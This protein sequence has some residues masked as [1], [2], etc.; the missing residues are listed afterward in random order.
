MLVFVY[1]LNHYYLV[2][3]VIWEVALLLR[4]RRW[5]A[6]TVLLALAAG[7]YYQP[8]GAAAAALA[9]AL[10]LILLR[11]QTKRRVQEAALRCGLS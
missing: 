5:F 11:G 8:V 4:V 6:L 10:L 2:S 7:C 1:R 9:V 3:L